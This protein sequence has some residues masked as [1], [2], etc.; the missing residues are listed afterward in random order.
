MMKKYGSLWLSFLVVGFG[1]ITIAT[2]FVHNFGQFLAVRI[3]LGCF[4]GGVIP[5]IAFLLSR[6]YRRHELV[7][8]IG[9]FLAL[10]PTLSGAFGGLLAAGLVN[11]TSIGS[12]TGWRKIFLV[13]GIIVSQT[14]LCDCSTAIGAD[15][16][17]HHSRP[18][19]DRLR[20]PFRSHHSHVA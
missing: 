1:V 5:A 3:L 15:L 12:V 16:L 7:F 4:E 6:F 9:I 8:R 20:L 14:W 18:T 19:D 10:G 2:A 11:G 17:T 13:E